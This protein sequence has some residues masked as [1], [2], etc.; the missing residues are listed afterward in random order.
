MDW[1]TY[2]HCMY[3]RGDE[4]VFNICIS[5]HDKHCKY[6]RGGELVI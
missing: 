3:T 6:T 4:H 2:K 5:L 1:G